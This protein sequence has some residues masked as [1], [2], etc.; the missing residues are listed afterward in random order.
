MFLNKMKSFSI[1]KY[2]LTILANSKVKLKIAKG[3]NVLII[4][5]DD[6]G[7]V[8]TVMIVNKKNHMV[9]V[10]GVNVVKKTVKQKDSSSDQNFV[11]VEKPIHISN[12]K[13][14]ENKN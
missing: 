10:S 7:K 12:V 4:S 1:K 5:G 11:S 9:V 13:K 3:D 6:K 2:A 8:G 14:I